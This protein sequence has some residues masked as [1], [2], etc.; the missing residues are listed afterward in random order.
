MP[1]L[2]NDSRRHAA[3]KIIFS[4]FGF[5]LFSA[6]LL[7][8]FYSPLKPRQRPMKW[9]VSKLWKKNCLEI[10]WPTAKVYRFTLSPR[11]KKTSVIALKDALST[12]HLSMLIQPQ[13]LE[14]VTQTISRPS[15]GLITDSKRNIKACPCIIS[16]MTNIPVTP[17]AMA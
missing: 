12:G 2:K 7:L 9:W 17:S 16:K 13:F 14:V 5:Y 1:F 6:S 4:H 15:Q 10:F 8:A 11:T 3:C